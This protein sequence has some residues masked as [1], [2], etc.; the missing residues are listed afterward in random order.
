MS[1]K[2]PEPQAFSPGQGGAARPTTFLSLETKP[3]K[4]MKVRRIG[5]RLGQSQIVF[6]RF[7]HIKPIRGPGSLP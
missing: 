7:D 5:W 6:A 2:V 3:Q 1:A 4:Q